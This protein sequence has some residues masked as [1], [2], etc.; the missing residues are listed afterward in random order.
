MVWFTLGGK[1]AINRSW[2]WVGTILD[3]IHKNLQKKNYKPVY[4]FL[5][6]ISKVLKEHMLLMSQQMENLHSEMESIKI[7]QRKT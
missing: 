3:L 6:N 5:K 7:S 1:K 2:L 4:E